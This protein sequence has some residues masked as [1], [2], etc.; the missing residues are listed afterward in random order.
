MVH[1]NPGRRGVEETPEVFD[2]SPPPTPQRPWMLRDVLRVEE[3]V[4]GLRREFPWVVW[5]DNVEDAGD[6]IRDT[7][8]TVQDVVSQG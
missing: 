4:H 6:E 2:T 8:P 7:C 5:A 1:K 3:D